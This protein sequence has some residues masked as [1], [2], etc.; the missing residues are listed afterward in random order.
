M[1][2]WIS[3]MLW[4]HLYSVMQRR[5]QN[6]QEIHS[7]ALAGEWWHRDRVPEKG[8]WDTVDSSSAKG[9]RSLPHPEEAAKGDPDLSRWSGILFW[10]WYKVYGN[11]IIYIRYIYLIWVYA[12]KTCYFI[13]NTIRIKSFEQEFAFVLTTSGNI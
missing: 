10:W 1:P 2:F 7:S 8:V 6:S 4:I 5:W 9:V 13:V 12:L 3:L 11:P